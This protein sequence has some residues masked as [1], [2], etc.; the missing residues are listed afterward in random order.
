MADIYLHI[1]L[2]KTGTSS[3]QDFFAL[4]QDAL[5]AEGWCYPRTGRDGPAHHPL[6]AAFRSP[7]A[8]VP[9]LDELRAEIADAP[10]VVL[11]SEDF[12]TLGTQ[13]IERVA[14]TFKGHRVQVLLYVREHL[15]YLASWYQQ[16]I[17]ASHESAPFDI[18]CYVQRKPMAEIAHR[19]AEVF[20]IGQVHVRLYDRAQLKDGDV[21]AD[22]AEVIG[23][24]G[25]LGR[26]VRKPYE[27]NPSV[28]GNL[29]FVK[30]VVN[31]FLTKPQAAQMVVETNELSKLRPE[32]RGAMAV[33]AAVADMVSA[34]YREDRRRLAARHG[35]VI[36][37]V[38]GARPGH[39][40]PDFDTLRGHWQYLVEV[41][42]ARGYRF[43]RYARMVQSGHFSILRGP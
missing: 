4:N 16:N 31:C 35:V 17:Q 26:F 3:L 5:R 34:M 27:S 25:D 9:L 2:N 19:W 12:H 43:G 1:G 39:L 24:G 11:S 7:D 38:P 29:L 6:S 41:S 14:E 10:R 37:P 20:G 33:D 32:Y 8:V 42:E 13:A 40:T 28:S 36:D 22:M 21:V 23:L 18:F 15:P 30:R